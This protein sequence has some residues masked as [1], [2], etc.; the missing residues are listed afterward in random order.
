MINPPSA[1]WRRR[2]Q[3]SNNYQLL[4]DQNGG[5]VR[6]LAEKIGV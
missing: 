6:Q 4:N 1:N 5:V 2:M 3:F